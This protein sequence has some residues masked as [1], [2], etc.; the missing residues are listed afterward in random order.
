MPIA[1][2]LSLQVERVLSRKPAITVMS[3]E[4]DGDC[5]EVHVLVNGRLWE[6]SAL[7]A[8]MARDLADHERLQAWIGGNMTP[9]G[10]L[11]VEGRTLTDR[12]TPVR[13]YADLALPLG[14]QVFCDELDH[15][16]PAKIVSWGGGTVQAHGLVVDELADDGTLGVILY[17]KG[18]P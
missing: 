8:R 1:E 13:M 5:V 18:T 11:V 16:I 9:I 14:N 7:P 15:V 6:L 4:I 17:A 10:P 3:L 12:L 2:P